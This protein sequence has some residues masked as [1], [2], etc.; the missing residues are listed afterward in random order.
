M[1]DLEKM[2]KAI[3]YNGYRHMINEMSDFI[4][5]EIIGFNSGRRLA[6]FEFTKDG[7]FILE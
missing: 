6:R 2:I 1:T 5:L 4:I 7:N 3:S